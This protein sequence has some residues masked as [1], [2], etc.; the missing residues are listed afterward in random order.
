MQ[1]IQISL[2]QKQSPSLYLLLVFLIMASSSIVLI[3]PAPVDLGIAFLL[4]TGILFQRLKFS[5]ANLTAGVIFLYL[6]TLA[7]LISMFGLTHATL[8]VRDFAITFYLILSWF[9]FIGIIEMYG[10]KAIKTL[11]YGY[12][13][14]AI[15][16]AVIGIL[17]FFNIIPWQ[18]I[19]MKF[20]RV[21]GLFKDPNVFAL[22]YTSLDDWKT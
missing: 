8:G 13:I 4:A 21:K 14:A 22:S 9:L 7:S 6:F 2:P 15:F 11:L 1:N 12:A 19:L 10:E 17:T 3:E 16:S 20:S 5:Y 18:D